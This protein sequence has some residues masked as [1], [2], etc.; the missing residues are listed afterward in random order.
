MSSATSSLPGLGL[1]PSFHVPRRAGVD[2]YLENTIILYLC[3]CDLKVAMDSRQTP[4]TWR[5][6]PVYNSPVLKYLSARSG[7]TVAITWSLLHFF[8]T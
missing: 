1:F 3:L 4:H 6:A 7:K 2:D 8:A 5:S